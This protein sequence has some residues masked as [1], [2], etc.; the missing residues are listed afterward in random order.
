MKKLTVLIFTLAFIFCGTAYADEDVMC[1]QVITFGQNP[2]TLEW[3]MFPTPCDV[4]DG[5]ETSMSRPT[6]EEINPGYIKGDIMPTIAPYTPDGQVSP[7]EPYIAPFSETETADYTLTEDDNGKTLT[8]KTGET[9]RVILESNPSTGYNWAVR[10]LDQN[11][12]EHTYNIYTSDCSDEQ[13]MGCGGKEEIN[14]MAIA[15]GETTLE[16]L[17]YRGWEGESSAI[18]TFTLKASVSGDPIIRDDIVIPNDDISESGVVLPGSEAVVS[19]PNY[20]FT[21]TDDG[22]TASVGKGESV[23]IT[24]ESNPSTGYK[25]NMKASEQDILKNTANDYTSECEEGMMGCGGKEVWDF[26]AVASGTATLEMLYYRGWEQESSAIR[27][28]TLNVSVSDTATDIE[29]IGRP[30]EKQVPVL[31]DD[32]DAD[33][34]PI[35]APL[36]SPGDYNSDGVIDRGDVKEKRKDNDKAF[37]TWKKE[38]WKMEKDCGDYNGNG[39]TDKKDLKEKKAD[40]D[41]SLKT[42]EKER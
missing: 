20:T 26:T 16:M 42:W 8:L 18:K 2:E 13:V 12:L 33:I 6:D 23:R 31:Y 37:K 34:I 9:V 4:P 28:F 21:E 35:I 22:K 39:V 5:W 32:D 27:T 19:V 25:W 41:R 40:L 38:C 14:F 30:T 11:I 7:Q 29:L 1:A 3:E 15:S 10:A 36:S 24:L 17:Y